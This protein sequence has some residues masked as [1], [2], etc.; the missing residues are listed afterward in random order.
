MSFYTEL[1]RRGV[2]QV[3]AAYLVF[4]WLL[5]QVA[6]TLLPVFDVQDGNWFYHIHNERTDDTSLS[7]TVELNTN[8]VDGAWQTNGVEWV[9]ESDVLNKFKAVTNRTDIGNREFVRLK[10]E[11]E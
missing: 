2:L 8:L 6:S 3:G 1:K 4:W 7:Y 9:G 10:I 5:I 11:Q